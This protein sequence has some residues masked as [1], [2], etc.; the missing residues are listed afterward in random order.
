MVVHSTINS[1]LYLPPKRQSS[2]KSSPFVRSVFAMMCYLHLLARSSAVAFFAPLSPPLSLR[3]L[4]L[5]VSR[6]HLNSGSYIC[7]MLHNSS[8]IHATS[9]LSLHHPHSAR[10]RSSCPRLPRCT[11]RPHSGVLP[12]CFIIPGSFLCTA[13]LADP[14]LRFPTAS[15]SSAQPLPHCSGVPSN[16]FTAI[17]AT[18]ETEKSVKEHWCLLNMC[19]IVV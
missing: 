19:R 8:L 18:F 11:R 17:L 16:L 2:Q 9:N 5:T 3:F 10:C 13:C 15:S 14:A 4:R 7:T 6:R 1:R 12:I